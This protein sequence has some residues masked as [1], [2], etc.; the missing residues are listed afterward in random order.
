MSRDLVQRIG[1]VPLIESRFEKIRGVGEY[2]QK[3]RATACLLHCVQVTTP[4]E[5]HCD[6]RDVGPPT[7]HSLQVSGPLPC[8][9]SPGSPGVLDAKNASA[10]GSR[11]DLLHLVVGFAYRSSDVEC[12]G[13][14]QRILTGVFLVYEAVRRDG[15]QRRLRSS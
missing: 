2:L 1:S 14:V 7:T 13:S 10:S 15:F 6:S 12:P 11:I 8:A 4:A 9:Q 3:A 5:P